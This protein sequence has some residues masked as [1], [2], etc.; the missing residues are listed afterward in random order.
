MRVLFVL[1][2]IAAVLC[3]VI[4]A[5][6]DVRPIYRPEHDRAKRAA[7]KAVTKKS[8]GKFTTPPTP[9]M[10]EPIIDGVGYDFNSMDIE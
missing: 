8:A 4:E 10:D 7:A 2:L 5:A 1:L 6:E 3:T 9:A